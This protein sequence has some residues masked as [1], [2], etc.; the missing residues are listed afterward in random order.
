MSGI[1]ISYRREDTA[2]NAG[3]IY[4][5][6]VDRFGRERVYRDVDSGQPGEDFVEA[7]RSRV[8]GSDVLLAL[9]GPNWLKATDES[10]GWRLA[11]EDDLVRVEIATAL[12]R[13]IRVIP[14]LL[15]GAKM[16][17][18]GD[19]PSAL[20]KLAHRNALE[21]R[22]THFEQ[23]VSL[24]LEHLSPRWFR[25]RWMRRLGR[26]IAWGAATLLLVAGIG[27]VYLSQVAL[28]PEQ[29]R[30][31]LTQID[32][33][34]TPDAFVKS[35]ELNDTKSVELFLKA[36]QDPNVTNRRGVTALQWAAA[37]GNLPLMKTLLRSG[38]N[39]EGALRW[40]AK[41]G[42]LE[43]LQF[44][45]SKGPTR[46]VL[47]AALIA[48]GDEADAVRELLDHRAN[49]NAAAEDGSTALME[50]A[51]RAKSEAISLLLAHGASVHA[52]RTDRWTHGMTPLYFAATG[53]GD[54]EAAI[55]AATLLLGK[56]ADLNTR[57]VDVN[58]TE[59]WTPLLAAMN[60]G[61][62]KVA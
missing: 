34:Y 29:A 27:G 49:P 23:D 59:G 19:L 39:T 55:E 58:N 40:A 5:R 43:A 61:H 17:G 9:I 26:P 18:A 44:L 22:D 25:H 36:G 10:G 20:S 38:A 30:V 15:H 46:A 11:S 28:T 57:A 51:R 60:R 50:A 24:L 1:F 41:A 56:G 35:A 62:W 54:E 3:R 48:A 6:L 42:Q 21:I 47:D 33:P 2:G 53:S 32:V 45:L 52:A 16:P 7:I 8:E 37:H 14:V 12:E 31:R 4:D 13:G